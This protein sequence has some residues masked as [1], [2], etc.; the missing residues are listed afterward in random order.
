[1]TRFIDA[2]VHPPV[3]EFLDGP[4][5]PFLGGLRNYRQEPVGVQTPD[6]LAEFY[7]SRDGKAVLL[8]WNSRPGSGYR[9][10]GNREIRALVD[11][12]PDVFWGFGAVEPTGGAGSVAAVHQ[13]ARIGLAGLV[14]HPASEQVAP[15]ERESRQLWETAV[16]HG[17]VVLIHTG[18]T[19][20]GA[21]MAG[22]GGVS[23][24]PARPIH[25]DR[26]AAVYPEMKIILA[27]T[28]RL[29]LDEALAISQHKS[30][31]H[32]CLSGVSPR[33]MS[34]E[35]ID[36]IRGP[37]LDRVHFGSDYPFG[38]PDAWLAEWDSL[39][40]PDEVNQAVLVDNVGRLLDQT[41]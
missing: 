39:G 35:L 37:L 16:E 2:H 26:L 6:D 27:H 11:S 19:R 30:N 29:W 38:D 41:G 1:M 31:V 14:F 12:A 5:G 17:L 25:V 21:G 24:E 33:A 8:G 20:L 22:G 3:P 7:R 32:L 15:S 23:L 34:S 4:M 36:L 28:G 10:L 40:L 13:A 18:F 9:T